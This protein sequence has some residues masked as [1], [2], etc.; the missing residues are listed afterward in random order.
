VLSLLELSR[1]ASRDWSSSL[2][3]LVQFDAEVIHVERVSFWSVSDRPSAI[4]CEVGYVARLRSFELGATVLETD[5][6]E[7]FTAMREAPLVVMADVASDPRCRGLRAYCA[8]RGISSMLDVGVY[9]CGQLAGI[10]C[11]EHV[12]PPRRWTP[13]EE[14]FAAA[15]G[16]AVATG[17][18]ERGHSNARAAASEGSFL[19]HL[20]HALL[21]SLDPAEIANRAVD[22]VM[23]RLGRGATLWTANRDGTLELAAASHADASRR[24]ELAA[25]ARALASESRLTLPRRVLA[26]KQALLIP[27]S[28]PTVLEE[29]GVPDAQRALGVELGFTTL[30][31]VPLAVGERTLGVMAFFDADRRFGT[32]D[33]EL[34]KEVADRVAS[35]LENARLHAMA[36]EAIRVRDEFIELATHELW[37]PLTPLRLSAEA[38]LR[39]AQRSGDP[40]AERRT[41][42]SVRQVKKLEA[43]V[44]RMFE[45]SQ[46][47]AGKL[48]LAPVKCDLAEIVARGVADEGERARQAG[49]TIAIHAPSPVVGEWDPARMERAVAELVDNAVKFG[50]G[51]PI[52][53]DVGRD[54][55]HATLT[56]RDHGIG[57]PQGRASS[58]FA[59]FERAAP[60]EQYSGLGLG[61]Y[62]AK[63]IVDA[64]GGSMR[65]DAAVPDGTRLVVHLPLASA[66]TRDSSSQ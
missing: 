35:A 48:P 4:Y 21:G 6:P 25:R 18:A 14:Q 39:R 17:L 64:H 33:L 23:P 38:S 58:I 28:L 1:S 24:R 36:L 32:E 12:G 43:L 31:A 54:N 57:I 20:S 47:R 60:K 10:L 51:K 16:Q 26:Q 66:A 56:I 13:H 37:T 29:Y 42:V 22:L 46:I 52:E 59:R 45:A 3:R 63:S 41:E 40:R 8:A 61:L 7:Y 5:A 19:E 34:A 15:V 30:M 53:I 44:R 11:H 50:S 62:I 55:A 65:V 49:A 27:E 9:W 2:R